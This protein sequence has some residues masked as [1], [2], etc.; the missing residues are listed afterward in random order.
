MR[1]L[2]IDQH[3]DLAWLFRIDD[4]KALPLNAAYSALI[5]EAAIAPCAPQQPMRL[6]AT[7]LRRA[8]EAMGR[9]APLAGNPGIFDPHERNHLIR[10]RAKELS[11][12]PQTILKDL[13]R[14]WAGGQ[15][16]AALAGRFDQCG[17]S[18]R[19]AAKKPRGR[20]P[21]YLPH[22]T[23]LMTSI[24]ERH[25]DDVIR[26][27]YLRN[28]VV[29]VPA[30]FQ[31]LLE[32]HY[33]YADGNGAR[34]IKQPGEYPSLRQF[35]YYLTSHY[36]IEERLRGRKGDKEFER[37]S[38]SRLGSALDDCFGVGH[39][40]E[41][42]ATIADV[43]LVAIRDRSRIIGKPT[44]Y[45]I[46][47]KWSRLVVGYYVGLE[48]PSWPAA[49]MAIVN[50]AE[51]KAAL[52]Q[53]YGIPYDPSDWPA[54]SVYPQVFVG[55]R[56]EML[57]QDSSLLSNNLAITVKNAPSL[58]PDRKGTVECGFKLIQRSMADV[59]P[60]YEPPENV[61]KR[62][63]KKYDKD[64]CLTLDEF[65][66]ILLRNIIAHN[67]SAMKNYPLSAEQLCQGLSPTPIELWSADIK[68]RAGSLTRY[69][70]NLV[71]FSLLPKD[72]AIV[73]RE[74]IYFRGCHYTCSEAMERGWFVRAGQRRFTVDISYDRRLADCIYLHDANGTSTYIR[75]VLTDRSSDYKGLSFEEVAA[76]EYMRSLVRKSTEHLTAQERADFHGFTDPLVCKAKGQMRTVSQGKSRKSRRADIVD[77]RFAE[78][79]E[80]RQEEA[81]M[82]QP[83]PTPAHPADVISLATR[84]TEPAHTAPSPTMSLAEKL[85]QKHQEMLHG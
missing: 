80:R 47:D 53:R 3:A 44:L 64:A 46:Y 73:T 22:T 69:D 76:Y 34:H 35:R 13:R 63:G 16:I 61:H 15:T 4:P 70:E 58:R 5:S 54:Q 17:K 10:T 41:I 23:Y 6:S 45:L 78:R 48:A 75:A 18:P 77:D 42:D 81:R 68:R 66:A 60:G 19:T 24:D 74:G 72:K 11:C 39:I 55:D 50:I 7:A 9:I 40:Y 56:G 79:R 26:K 20:S 27:H 71:R 52:C 59:V 38:R 25:M 31:R 8:T 32:Q 2:A 43:F 82:K 28:A 84:K 21:R 1:V 12:S 65:T 57:S 29:S 33:S 83:A 67:R 62:R 30:A 36:S 37:N 14:Y 51:D 49:M 85:R